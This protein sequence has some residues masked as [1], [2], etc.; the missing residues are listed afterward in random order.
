MK[1]N[2]MERYYLSKLDRNRVPV[3]VAIIMDG[4]GRWGL[5]NAHDRSYGHKR[6]AETFET[7]ADFADSIGIRYLTVFAFSTENWKRPK[8]EVDTIMRLLE[9][10]LL[11]VQKKYQEYNVVLR[12][13]GDRSA[14]SP[15]LISLMEEAERLTGNNTG[16][17][18]NIALNYGGRSE[19]LRAAR[20][21]L[22]EPAFRE[23]PE[24]LTEEAFARYLDTGGQPDPDL[25]I[26]PGGEFRIS[27][28]LLWQCAYS[29]FWFSKVLWPE[30]R[31]VHLL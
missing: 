7:I 6:G 18:V 14:L 5:K 8:D 21:L 26:K 12:F 28:F 10:Y 17:T 1:Y 27:N 3:H 2:L 30:F 16:I 24:L 11:K 29:E 19:I 13:I 20:K 15:S 23:Q 9:E 31:P 22:R 25:L 4:N